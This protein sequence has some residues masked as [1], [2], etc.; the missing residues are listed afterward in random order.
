MAGTGD[1]EMAMILPPAF[2]DLSVWSRSPAREQTPDRGLGWDQK[3]QGWG[4][5]CG[6]NLCGQRGGRSGRTFQREAEQE[7]SLGRIVGVAH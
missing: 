7:Q 4:P 1:K 6:P 2:E 3:L 5:L